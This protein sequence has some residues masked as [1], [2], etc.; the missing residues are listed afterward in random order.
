MSEMTPCRLCNAPLHLH[1]LQLPEHHDPGCERAGPWQGSLVDVE[2]LTR[3]RDA[4]LDVASV[5][6]AAC[7]VYVATH[8]PVPESRCDKAIDRLD[9]ALARLAEVSRG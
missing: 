7:G 3:E 9:A 1:N 4:L 5:A 8:G 6:R 2:R